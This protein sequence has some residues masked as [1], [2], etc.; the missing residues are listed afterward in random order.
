VSD[1]PPQHAL[2]L[3][4]DHQIVFVTMK[5]NRH[6]DCRALGRGESSCVAGA[7]ASIITTLLPVQLAEWR[8]AAKWRRR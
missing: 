2:E 5:A 8:D 1:A 7:A 3:L 4:E 6:A